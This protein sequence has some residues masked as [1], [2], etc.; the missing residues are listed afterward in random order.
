MNTPWTHHVIE[1]EALSRAI[2]HPSY[3]D[4]HAP[5]DDVVVIDCRFDLMNPACGR[6][7]YAQA[8]IPGAHYL[9]LNEDLSAPVA[10]HGGR[11]PFPD[12]T[13]FAAR[14]RDCGVNENTSIVAYDDNKSAFAARLWYLCHHIGHPRVK[15]LNGG[16]SAWKSANLPVTAETSAH[17]AGTIEIHPR[18]GHIL[19]YPAV[20]TLSQQLPDNTV[21]IDSRETPRYLGE[22][23]PIDP[24]A[25]HIPG[26]RNLPWMS[27]VG[28]NG[29][30]LPEAQ[31][32]ERWAPVL[33]DNQQ[34]VIYCGSGVTACVNLFSLALIGHEGA[35]LYAGSWSDWCSYQLT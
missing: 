3:S 7:L 13:R 24:I 4:G 31:H 10:Q 26:A 34:L 21:L 6:A 20:H 29:F 12:L 15:I 32:R 11:H 30:F 23:E 1:V 8:H 22:I 9:D 27:A 19:D 18:Q 2:A 28:E 17:R 35:Q 33:K 14:L 25:G 16:F 5:D